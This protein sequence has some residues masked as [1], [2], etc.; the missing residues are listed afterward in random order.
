MKERAGIE[1]RA[2]VMESKIG[3]RNRK[4]EGEIKNRKEE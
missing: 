4:Q 2:Q 3:R 1:N